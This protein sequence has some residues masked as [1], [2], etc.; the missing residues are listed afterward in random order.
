MPDRTRWKL[1]LPGEFHATTRAVESVSFSG[2]YVMKCNFR[3]VATEPPKS[4]TSQAPGAEFARR[5]QMEFEKLILDPQFPCVGAKAAFNSAAIRY[6]F[7]DELGTD[8]AT[9]QLA[10]DLAR[11][12]F[13]VVAERADE[14]ASMVAIFQRP[15]S[16]TEVQF[17][18]LLWAQLRSLHE[19]DAP[20]YI[21]DARVSS[22]PDAPDFSFSF[23]TQA[24]YVVGMHANSSRQ[25][26][27]FT[28]PTLVFNP[29]EQFE[30]L[31]SDGNWERM[32]QTIRARDAALQGTANPM[33]SDF[34][35][36][37]EARQYSGR[38]VEKDWRAPFVASGK[39]PFGH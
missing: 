27:R 33:L 23:A 21:W 30:R 22:D 38:A 2:V 7:Y 17:E 16:L 4:A 3:Q 31:R 12:T 35:E 26:R 34:G 6:G 24:Y 8:K 5:A 11:F 29:H 19:V 20:N 15:R 14:Y 18:K 36:M 1:P 25:A 37:S 13:T 28:W 32:K 39:C 10:C 9:E